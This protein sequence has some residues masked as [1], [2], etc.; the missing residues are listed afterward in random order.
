MEGAPIKPN[1]R[2]VR[3]YFCITRLTGYAKRRTNIYRARLMSQ[4]KLPSE[5]R[6]VIEYSK[7]GYLLGF[8]SDPYDMDTKFESVS[9]ENMLKKSTGNFDHLPNPSELVSRSSK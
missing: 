7:G 2:L 8:Y 1:M 6:S 3:G 5:L 9:P 4:K